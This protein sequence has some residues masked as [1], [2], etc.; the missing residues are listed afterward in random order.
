[1]QNWLNEAWGSLGAIKFGVAGAF[2]RLLVDPPETRV[3]ALRVFLIGVFAAAGGIPAGETVEG[4]ISVP[5]VSLAAFVAGF[6][7][8]AVAEKLL[9]WIRRTT[10]EDWINAAKGR[11]DRG[12]SG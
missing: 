11:R 6:L 1:M 9:D 5:V 7:G 2:L 8:D 12:D 3:G 4:W 10:P